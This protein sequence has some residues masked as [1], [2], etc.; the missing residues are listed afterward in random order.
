MAC[1]KPSR[2][3]NATTGVSMQ[4]NQTEKSLEAPENNPSKNSY[5]YIFSFASSV[6]PLLAILLATMVFYRG[7]DVILPLIAAVVLAL[8]F[9]PIAGFLERY[10]GRALSSAVAALMVVAV[11]AIM[12]YLFAVGVTTVAAEITAYSDNIVTKLHSLQKGSHLLSDLEVT[13]NKI[14]GSVQPTASPPGA[15][16]PAHA[17]KVVAAA[18]SSGL[19]SAADLSFG[20]PVLD[21]LFQVSLIVILLFFLL[22]SRHELR[23]RFVRLAARAEMIIA[24]QAI[25]AAGR[26]IA[27]Y[28]LLLSCVNFGIGVTCATAVWLLGIPN[29]YLWG[30]LAMMLR[31]IPYVGTIASATLPALI[32]FAIF[33]GWGKCFEVIAIYL[34]ADQIA[35]QLIEPFV[36]GPEIDLSPVALLVAAMYWSWLWGLPGLLLAA[37]ITV[38][39]K[40]AGDHIPALGFFSVL[41]GAE[42]KLQMHHHFYRLL[43]ERDTAGARDLAM[44][45]WN[46]NNLSKTFSRILVPTLLMSGDERAANNI[47]KETQQF[48]IDETRELIV[49]LGNLSAMV[50][51]DDSI[52]ALA[53]CAPG[54]VH[55]LGILMVAERL[56]QYAVD[57]RLID[58]GASIYTTV[59]DSQP[60][61]MLLSCATTECLPNALEC[62]AK[63]RHDFRDLVI[64]AGGAAAVSA[65]PRIRRAGCDAV[66]VTVEQARRAIWRSIE[67]RSQPRIRARYAPAGIRRVN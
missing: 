63:L 54:E 53:V 66:C 23:D 46:E 5:S 34:A 43:L 20:L 8:V 49:E 60:E 67:N 35:V 36:V 61:V 30:A 3:N 16:G 32:A 58:E 37:P 22:F 24:P 64:I 50:S 25:E 52:S 13:V 55:N 51:P 14:K 6:L 9:S 7:R 33:P 65:S 12:G 19:F 18:P 29:P 39:L 1:L 44:N 31:F 59:Q 40:I 45:Y 11:V 42:Q 38:C 41:L 2:P 47:N 10:I 15:P 57:T 62:V 17:P 4:L 27:H 48:I 28:L 56:K 21:A 26:T